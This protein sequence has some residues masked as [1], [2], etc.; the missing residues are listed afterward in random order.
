M[1]I[2]LEDEI[3]LV[4]V[5]RK[6]QNKNT[7]IR[8]KEGNLLYVTTG[9]FTSDR[10]VLSIIHE[11][12][13]ALLKMLN[14]TREKESSRQGFRYLGN[15]FVLIRNDAKEISSQGNFLY[16]P[17]T[18]D[19]DK[20]LE[21]EA[22][23]IFK[24]EFDSCYDSFSRSI[25]KPSLSIRKMKSRWG[26]CNTK[27]CHVTLNFEL[28]HHDVKYLR[29]VIMHELSHLCYP[30]HSKDFWSVVEEN[31]ADYKILRKDMKLF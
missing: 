7:Y 10:K 15:N 17:S 5:V 28:I 30:N 21:K 3:Y 11:N 29:Y 19:A 23:R 1:N 8:I 4:E 20:W 31:C 6:A 26:V 14:K 9:L 25:P 2:K 16:V 18:F 22:R 27:R 13:K 12:E 24:K